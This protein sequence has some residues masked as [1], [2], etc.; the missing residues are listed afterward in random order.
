MYDSFLDKFKK[1]Y[2]S[3]VIRLADENN[4]QP[5]NDPRTSNIVAASHFSI[6]QF[7]EALEILGELESS[8]GDD[9]GYLGLYGA[10]LRRVGNYKS[11][12]NIF[13]RALSI[14]PTSHSLRN[15]YANLLIDMHEF[16]KAEAILLKLL[17]EN[18]EYEDAK[19]NSKRLDAVR[20]LFSKANSSNANIAS[21][22]SVSDNTLPSQK[23]ILDPL[24]R[25][26]SRDEVKNHGRLAPPPDL[27]K[28]ASS[29]DSR[30][31]GLEKLKLAQVAVKESN[32]DYALSLCSQTHQEIGVES[33]IYDCASD[34]YIP[35]NKFLEA[36]ICILHSIILAQPTMKHYINLVSLASMRGD[37]QLAEVYLQKAI[38]LDSTHSSLGKLKDFLHK[39]KS[40]LKS[41]PFQFELQ[42][43]SSKLQLHKA[44]LNV[45]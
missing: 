30:A 5:G 45:T 41:T 31:I 28:A 22:D 16:S 42:W 8:L 33:L 27:K 18:P 6:G 1:G 32:Y 39:R 11:S 9:E 4:I 14:S 29:S 43:A 25:A 3:E 20:S 38:C 12:E 15:N 23:A 24:M 17:K 40:E 37:I 36:E 34:G 13:E 7:T 19:E 35:K 26:F 2:Y 44:E 10:A 21:S